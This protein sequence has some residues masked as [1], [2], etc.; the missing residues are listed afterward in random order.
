MKVTAD[1]LAGVVDQFGAL[2]RAE[3]QDAAAEL[4]FKADGDFEPEA[5]AADVDDALHSYHLLA[6]DSDAVEGTDAATD[7]DATWLV[8]GPIAFPTLPAGAA[9]LPHIMDL[10]ARSVDREAAGRAAEAQF[11]TDAAAAAEGGDDDRI[12]ALLDVSYELEAWGP[13]DLAAAR[14]H[15]D[16]ATE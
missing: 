13:V 9:D 3:L 4:A 14:D 5:F 12:A 7:E 8:P 6:V 15:L 10:D 11:R 2:T 1:E 16:A